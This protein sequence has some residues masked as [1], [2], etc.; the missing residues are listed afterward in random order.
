MPSPSSY[1]EVKLAHGELVD[2]I[3]N[4]TQKEWVR[5]CEKLGL[6]V[7][8]AFGKGSHFA[9]Y[10]DNVCLPEDSS[11]CVVTLPVNIY[12]NFFKEI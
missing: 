8:P 11:C 12:S 1:R 5:V 3:K 4:L 2:R 6:Y 10:K 7:C 9:V